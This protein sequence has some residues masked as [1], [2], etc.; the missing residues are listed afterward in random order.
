MITKANKEVSKICEQQQDAT[1][2]RLI[3]KYTA[4]EHIGDIDLARSSEPLNLLKS[5]TL[6]TIP[7]LTR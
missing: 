2:P 6:V 3:D 7:Q 1:P 4:V 5:L